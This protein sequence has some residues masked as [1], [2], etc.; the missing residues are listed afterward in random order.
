[1]VLKEGVAGKA[2]LYTGREVVEKEEAVGED[3]IEAEV[4]E[5][6]EEKVDVLRAGEG[7]AWW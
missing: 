7:G 4:V 5:T 2:C 6:E 3:K 1:M